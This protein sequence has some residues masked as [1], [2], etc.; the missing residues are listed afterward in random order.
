LLHYR[1]HTHAVSVRLIPVPRYYRGNRAVPISV[2]SLIRTRHPAENTKRQYRHDY[3]PVTAH[4]RTEENGQEAG[5]R[6]SRCDT[7]VSRQNQTHQTADV[8]YLARL[9]T[10]LFFYPQP[11]VAGH[12][13]SN[14][15]MHHYECVA[16]CKD[17]S[18]HQRGRFCARSL[19]PCMPQDPAKTGHHER[20]SS[21]LLLLCTLRVAN[22]GLLENTTAVINVRDGLIGVTCGRQRNVSRGPAVR[23]PRS[24]SSSSYL[25]TS[26][27]I[28][29]NVFSI[30][31]KN[32]EIKI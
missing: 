2:H 5:C 21:E 13:Q 29:F 14:S 10:S 1:P 8:I 7:G 6:E 28:V 12:Y 23:D 19:A 25:H 31:V 20:S 27:M 16:L 17:I 18:L 24:T 3:R 11:S 30:D 9:F 22:N 26:G 32:V 15:S 4:R